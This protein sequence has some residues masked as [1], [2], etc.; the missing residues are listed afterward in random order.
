MEASERERARARSRGLGG[1]A[2]K[3]GR[4]AGPLSKGGFP[5][6]GPPNSQ[7]FMGPEAA[8]SRAS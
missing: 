6:Y 4:A 8:A 5:I 2:G 3:L 7:I 1:W